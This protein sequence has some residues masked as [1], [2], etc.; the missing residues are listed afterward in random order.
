[1][2]QTQA[3]LESKR[4]WIESIQK[5]IT[6]TCFS[7]CFQLNSLDVDGSC[8]KSC[9]QKYKQTLNV[10]NKTLEELGYE[11]HS[12][13]AYKIWPKKYP[14]NKWYY[15]KELSTYWLRTDYALERNYMTGEKF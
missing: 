15:S 7:K 1:M 3:Q 13:A 5:D 4:Q 6:S 11:L 8:L 12:Q 2:S 9:Y 14:M 10:T